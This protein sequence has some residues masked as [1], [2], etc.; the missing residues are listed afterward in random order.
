VLETLKSASSA[1]QFVK[2]PTP[3]VGT[4]VVA[5]MPNARRAKDD[6]I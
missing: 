1:A 2:G 4:P 6:K 3:G 5:G